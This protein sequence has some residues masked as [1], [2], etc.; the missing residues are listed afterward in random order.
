MVFNQPGQ[1]TYWRAFH[2]GRVLASRGHAVTLITT[3][4]RAKRRGQTYE[5]DG[6]EIVETPDLLPDV[7]R[8]GWDL[9]NTGYRMQWVRRRAFDLVHAFESRPAVIFP[10]LVAQRRGA[11]LIMDW[12]DWFGRGGAVEERPNPLGRAIFRV[13]E[14]YF[15]N[16]F[17]TRAAG[18]TVINTC[19]R[20][21]A[22]QL[23][24]RPESILLIRN[25]SDTRLPFLAH[26]TAR[27]MLS[28]PAEW[29]LIGY[30]GA[31]FS[32]DARF[33]ASAFNEVQRLMP[34]T[35]LVLVSYFNRSI[36]SLLNN[37]ASVIRY[38]QANP[39]E[40]YRWMAGCDVC[41]LPLCD[42]GANRGRWPFK[43]NMYMTA[44]RPVITTAVGDLEPVVDHY[45]LGIATRPDPHSFA[46]R[47][48]E[49]LKR[50]EKCEALGQAARRAA[51]GVFSWEELTVELE[52][53]YLSRL[54]SSVS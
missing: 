11:K 36:E 15:E 39:E 29:R 28:L 25:G 33:M 6:M 8:Y 32:Q 46:E 21:R 10:A 45:Q 13:L 12:C 40:I 30:A 24:V 9:W 16:S 44:G 31:I 53:F 18:T 26:A 4:R 50:K 43:L 14:T 41:W 22:L 49:L 5:L 3:S 7:F 23:G 52:Q 51:E 20:E 37:P 47:T 35:R 42:T 1:G 2:F 17:R 19:L 38:E 34:E 48:V 54:S 27:Q